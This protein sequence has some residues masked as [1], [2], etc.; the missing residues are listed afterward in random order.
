MTEIELHELEEVE[1][2]NGL[3]KISNV[4][5]I[6]SLGILRFLWDHER[7]PSQDW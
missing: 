7:F 1:L 6:C 5:Q 3:M 4:T 2:S